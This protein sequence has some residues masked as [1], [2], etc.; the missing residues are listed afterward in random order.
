MDVNTITQLVGSLGFPILAC[1]ALFYDNMQTRKD[2]K[3]EM[4]QVTKALQNNTEVL[5]QLKEVIK[6][7]KGM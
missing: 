6:D 5:S 7:G 4:I 1:V 3:E 2:H